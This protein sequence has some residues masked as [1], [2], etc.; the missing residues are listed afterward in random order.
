LNKPAHCFKEKYNLWGAIAK[1]VVTPFLPENRMVLKKYF[2]D[3]PKQKN[4]PRMGKIN[5][6]KVI[7]LFGKN[8]E[9]V[10][11]Y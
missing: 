5:K 1:D 8:Y 9:E 10:E 2:I 11:Q 3:M 7:E 6:R 4:G